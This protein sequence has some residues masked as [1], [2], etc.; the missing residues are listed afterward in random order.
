MAVGIGA[1]AW[2]GVAGGRLAAPPEDAAQALMETLLAGRTDARTARQ[3][4]GLKVVPAGVPQPSMQACVERSRRGERADECAGWYA[5]FV[6]MALEDARGFAQEVAGLPPAARDRWLERVSEFA[7]RSGAAPL[8]GTQL[9]QSRDPGAVR[10]AK[11]FERGSG[12]LVRTAGW[13]AR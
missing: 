10:I 6:A 11:R 3:L 9:R 5:W 1:I 2:L 13:Q 4:G 7:A 12:G 8:V